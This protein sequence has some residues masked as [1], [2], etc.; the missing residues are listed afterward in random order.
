MMKKLPSWVYKAIL[1]S[2]F[3]TM[4]AGHLK[5]QCE[6]MLYH[7]RCTYGIEYIFESYQY[8]RSRSFYAT[9]NPDIYFKINLKKDTTYLMNVCEEFIK[10]GEMQLFL[11]D[12][13][14]ELIASS[15]TTLENQYIV[16]KPRRK[17]QFLLKARFE[18]KD[19][20]CCAVLIG[21]ITDPIIKED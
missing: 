4:N 12:K 10:H 20:G 3:I 5:A 2:A 15:D 7:E 6:N 21:M 18:D 17:G 16:F 1:A 9:S 13:N 14:E 8:F 19:A 11:Y